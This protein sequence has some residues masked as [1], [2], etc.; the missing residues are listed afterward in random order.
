VKVVLVGI[1]IILTA[2]LLYM[3]IGVCGVLL[4]GYWERRKIRK[5][6][7]E[8]ASNERIFDERMR[9]Q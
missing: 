8:W 4:E 6:K 7:R 2:F 9:K 3:I 1:L 5:E